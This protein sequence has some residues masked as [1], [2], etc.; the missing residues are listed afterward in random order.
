M[1]GF[2]IGGDMFLKK[3]KFTHNGETIELRELSALQRIEYLEYAADNQ[4]ADHDS[5]DPMV[6]IAAINKLDIKLSALVVSMSTLPLD[7]ATDRDALMAMHQQVMTSWPAE[8]L[9]EAGKKVM[10]LSGLLSDPSS[11][12]EGDDDPSE[13]DAGKS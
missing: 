9:T 2:F 11:A 8:A 7:K 4:V 6:Y 13:Y 5:T 3:D 12:E 10:A 1:A